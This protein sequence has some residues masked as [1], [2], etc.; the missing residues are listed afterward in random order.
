MGAMAVG[1]PQGVDEATI[2]DA[3]GEVMVACRQCEAPVDNDSAVTA[4]GVGPFCPGDVCLTE[5]AADNLERVV[6]W[7][8]D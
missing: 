6:R 4:M 2:S 8:R 3:A 5:W 1:L 7:I